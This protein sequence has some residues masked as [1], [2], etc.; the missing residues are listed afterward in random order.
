MVVVYM[1]FVRWE[2]E[3]GNLSLVDEEL[4]T[5]GNLSLVDTQPARGDWVD[6]KLTRDVRCAMSRH[7]ASRE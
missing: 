3:R 6:M 5:Y 1:S 2:R 7:R 4:V